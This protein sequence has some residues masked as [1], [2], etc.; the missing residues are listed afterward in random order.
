MWFIGFFTRVT[1]YICSIIKKD[2]VMIKQVFI[3]LVVCLSIFNNYRLYAQE[4]KSDKKNNEIN[5]SVYLEFLWP[6][7]LLGISYNSRIR[8]ESSWGYRIGIGYYYEK[9]PL[10]TSRYSNFGLLV[11]IEVNYLLGNRWYKLEVGLGGNLEYI[12]IKFCYYSYS[13]INY[14][15]QTKKDFFRTELILHLTFAINMA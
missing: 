6:S 8:P 14:R 9:S 4:V 7:N 12:R 5:R 3:V 11:P 1:N 2:I 10:F 13:N 15:Y